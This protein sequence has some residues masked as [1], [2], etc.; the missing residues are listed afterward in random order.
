MKFILFKPAY[1]VSFFLQNF[2][3]N[4]KLNWYGLGKVVAVRMSCVILRSFIKIR[5]I[6]FWW[7][8]GR[9]YCL[10]LWEAVLYNHTL[11]SLYKL[12]IANQRRYEAMP[13][14]RSNF[15]SSPIPYEALK[16]LSYKNIGTHADQ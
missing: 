3:R 15:K 13:T 16:L 9:L 12:V 14:T 6:L 7:S 4:I 2:L 5:S 1:H 8:A 10:T 11:F